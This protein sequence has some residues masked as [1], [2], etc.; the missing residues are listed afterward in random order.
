MHKIQALEKTLEMLKDA[1]VQY[2]WVLSCAC[3]AGILYSAVTGMSSEEVGTAKADTT[4]LGWGHLNPEIPFYAPLFEAGFTKEEVGHL[5]FLS[6]PQICDILGL[7]RIWTPIHR[8]ELAPKDFDKRGVVAK[9]IAAWIQLEKE[10]SGEHLVEQANQILLCA[11]NT[12]DQS[13]V[14]NDAPVQ[15]MAISN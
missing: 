8:K 3:N 11:Q 10:K 4:D 9:Y 5:E 2:N 12:G 1:N 6:D 7:E 14:T 15:S 13:P